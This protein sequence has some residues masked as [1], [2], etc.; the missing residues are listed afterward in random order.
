MPRK[1]VAGSY[2]LRANG[3]KRPG[4]GIFGQVS[5]RIPSPSF[6]PLYFLF[7]SYMFIRKRKRRHLRLDGSSASAAFSLAAASRRV[8]PR[9]L[10]DVSRRS[11]SALRLLFSFHPG[12]RSRLGMRTVCPSAAAFAHLAGEC[13][14]QPG[15][16]RR[17]VWLAGWVRRVIAVAR[18]RNTAAWARMRAESVL[19]ERARSGV[20]GRS[21][22]GYGPGWL[23]SSVGSALGS[24]VPGGRHYDSLSTPRALSLSAAA[25]GC[26]LQALLRL[27]PPRMTCSRPVRRAQAMIKTRPAGRYVCVCLCVALTLSRSADSGVFAQTWRRVEMKPGRDKQDGG[28]REKETKKGIPG[29]RIKR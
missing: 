11:A 9:V 5:A 24:A 27:Q 4:K 6:P 26:C 18:N 20:V 2:L 13:A 1:R 19:R 7:V 25:A 3:E 14:L 22:W 10:L 8:F 28:S 12:C 16:R 17:P 21:D 15:G 29:R 23:K